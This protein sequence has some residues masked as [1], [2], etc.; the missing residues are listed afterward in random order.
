MSM[1]MRNKSLSSAEFGSNGAYDFVE[2]S[3]SLLNKFQEIKER[4]TLKISFSKAKT[5]NKNASIFRGS[6][7]YLACNL[8]R[9]KLSQGLALFTP[10]SKQRCWCE[11]LVCEAGGCDFGGD[12][13]DLSRDLSGSRW[14]SV[15]SNIN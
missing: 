15:F 13:V 9:I 1:C 3:Q 4:F 14:E 5:Q 12:S 6:Q 7:A 2:S 8:C 11:D 10:A